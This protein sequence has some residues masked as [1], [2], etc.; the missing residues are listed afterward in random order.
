MAND[1]K[2]TLIERLD[3]LPMIR[4]WPRILRFGS[5]AGGCPDKTRIIGTHF[6]NR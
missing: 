1:A 6:E 2:G 5:G 4:A 3:R